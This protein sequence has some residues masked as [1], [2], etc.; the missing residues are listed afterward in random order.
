MGEIIYCEVEQRTLEQF[1]MC[2][3]DWRVIIVMEKAIVA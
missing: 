1:Y 3:L 2:K